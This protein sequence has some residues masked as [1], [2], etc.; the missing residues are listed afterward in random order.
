[1]GPAC[2]RSRRIGHLYAASQVN[3]GVPAAERP[4]AGLQQLADLM[5]AVRRHRR[6]T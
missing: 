3:G 4:G 1:M 6:A 5:V 2:A